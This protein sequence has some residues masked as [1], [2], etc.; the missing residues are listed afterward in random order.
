MSINI[1]HRN[2]DRTIAKILGYCLIGAN[3]E[4]R[5]V[6]VMPSLGNEHIFC[7]ATV[8]NLR[9]HSTTVNGYIA[10]ARLESL[11]ICGENP[12]RNKLKGYK[13]N[14]SE[15][16]HVRSFHQRS[17]DLYLL[18]YACGMFTKL[19]DSCIRPK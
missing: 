12:P 1:L 10:W 11:L 17:V 15:I 9:R 13:D 19:L 4:T 2:Q 5:I 14:I 18:V 6:M 16:K 3:T 8:L 7:L